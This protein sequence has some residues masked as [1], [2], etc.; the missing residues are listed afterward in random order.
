MVMS[1]TG[2]GRGEAA[3]VNYKVS[4]EMK[5]VNHRYLDAAIKMPKKLNVYEAELKNIL[6]EYAV[7]GKIDVYVTYECMSNA[8]IAIQYN[9]EAARQYISIFHEMSELFGIPDEI[10]APMLGRYPEVIATKTVE[11]DE[12]EL[13]LL[14]ETAFRQ[15][16]V[17]FADARGAEGAKLAE[18]I[19][20]KLDF[21]MDTVN[22]IDEHND[23][24]M[25]DYR[26]RLEN[27]VK[28][29]LGDV[30]VDER[31]MATELV[32]YADK[33][34]VDE[35]LVRLRSHIE[36]MRQVFCE[37]SAEGIG[38]RLDF[39]AQEMNRE[40]NTTLSKANNILISQRAIDLK[41]VIEKIREQIQNI[42]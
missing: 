26:T 24:I 14:V 1:M 22:F 16:C 10:T 4:V 6:K 18:D 25:R 29:L 42:E 27:K 7:R 8:D 37:E 15:A 2:F 38:R 5:S 30:T 21:L 17:M 32:L 35:E 3:D 40:A 13:Y 34:C 11:P 23:E 33:V 31:I 41:T 19:V 20:D 36:A 12:D 9:P 39:I 28:E